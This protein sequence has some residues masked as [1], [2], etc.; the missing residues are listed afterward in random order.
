VDA[1]EASG[2]DYPLAM[3]IVRL[4][5]LARRLDE[6]AAKC[7]MKSMGPL[8]AIFVPTDLRRHVENLGFVVEET[9]EWFDP[10]WSLI[11]AAEIVGSRR[12]LFTAP[13][14][15]KMK[16]QTIGS[17]LAFKAGDPV[18]TALRRALIAAI[19]LKFDDQLPNRPRR[20]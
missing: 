7:G 4:D 11:L 3:I 9:P 14:V 8:P 2:N 10:E 13:V 12:V 1:F 15:E 20:A 18:E 17:A 6:L 19:C 16:I 5:A